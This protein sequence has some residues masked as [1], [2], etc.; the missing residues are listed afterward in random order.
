MYCMFLDTVDKYTR[1]S[2]LT[3]SH[4]SAPDAGQYLCTGSNVNSTSSRTFSL[5]VEGKA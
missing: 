1:N 4:L 2:S 5:S 3:I